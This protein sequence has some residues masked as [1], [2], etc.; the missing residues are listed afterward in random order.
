M[1]RNKKGDVRHPLVLYYEVTFLS[2]DGTFVAIPGD[3]VDAGN[4]DG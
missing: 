3:N 1:F 2:F 4:Y